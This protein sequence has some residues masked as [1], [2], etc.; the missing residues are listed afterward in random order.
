M[1]EML[2]FA[3]WVWIRF[4]IRKKLAAEGS[5]GNPTGGS[6]RSLGRLPCPARP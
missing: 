1:T 5:A 2:Q 6:I 4:W 3:D